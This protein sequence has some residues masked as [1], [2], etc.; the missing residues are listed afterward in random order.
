MKNRS[1][2]ETV[3]RPRVV[4]G[5]VHVEQKL[6]EEPT[7]ESCPNREAPPSNLRLR[8]DS[9]PGCDLEREAV[10]KIDHSRVVE[11]RSKSVRFKT[12]RGV[13]VLRRSG[14]FVKANQEHR[15]AF[16]DPA[17]GVRRGHHVSEESLQRHL[18]AKRIDRHR[19]PQ[20]PFVEVPL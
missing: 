6:F 10:F 9:R 7:I 2:R 8:V 14:A 4:D 11:C 17:V 18:L 12:P 19:R 13:D 20:R 5:D 3:N 1:Q 15:G 16:E